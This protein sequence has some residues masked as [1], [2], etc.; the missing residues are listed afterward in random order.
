MARKT[1]KDVIRDFRTEQI[2]EAARVVIAKRG[3]AKTTL[4]RIAREAGVAKGT[5]YLYFEN[6]EAL[7]AAIHAWGHERLME[8]VREASEAEDSAERMLRATVRATLE[9]FDGELAFARAVGSYP[10]IGPAGTSPGSQEIRDRIAAY[11]RFLAA[12]LAQGVRAREF[13]RHDPAEAAVFL[14]H[15]TY[16][17]VGARVLGVGAEGPERAANRVLDYFLNGVCAR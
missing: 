17:E 8:R 4:A 14:T 5:L 10:A 6:K 11:T 1:R 16:A 3:Y 2:L 13:R 15:L 9:Y 7:L 12:L